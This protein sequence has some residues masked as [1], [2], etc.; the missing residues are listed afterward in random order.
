MDFAGAF[1]AVLSR[2]QEES[3]EV[4]LIGGL[5]LGASGVARATLDMD[6]L[7]PKEEASHVRTIMRSLGYT[8]LHESAEV[9]NYIHSEAAGGRVDFLYAHRPYA[10]A[11]LSRARE[12]SIGG[13]QHRVKVLRVEDQIG[14]KVQSS[15]NDPTRYHQDMADIEAL[16]RAHRDGVDRGLLKEYFELF[17]RG[18][19]FERLCQQVDQIHD[20]Q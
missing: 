14:L 9:A 17:E 8:L 16:L 15:S 18:K 4:A 10:R 11:M 1:Q 20:A 3:I 13:G 6:L 12:M 19:E 7:I 5:A 2:F